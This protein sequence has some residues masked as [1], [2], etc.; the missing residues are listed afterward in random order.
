MRDADIVNLEENKLHENVSSNS[1][2]YRSTDSRIEDI[3]HGE[4]GALFDAVVV[5]RRDDLFRV[6]GLALIVTFKVSIITCSL[7]VFA[8]L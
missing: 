2:L 4:A 5:L 6:I 3:L 7:F 8:H 1:S